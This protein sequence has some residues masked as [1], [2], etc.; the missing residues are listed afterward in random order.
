M[1][2]IVTGGSGFIG[3]AFIR[4]ILKDTRYSVINI[5]KLTYAS[6][7]DSLESIKNNERYEFFQLDICDGKKI[8]KLSMIISHRH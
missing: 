7:S 6:N 2:I 4:H 3:S 5:D 1:K 8:S